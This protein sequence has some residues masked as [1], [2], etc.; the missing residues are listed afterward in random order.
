MPNSLCFYVSGHGYGH[1]R[2]M[3][4][5]IREFARLQPDA[6]IRI[7]SAAPARVFE[8][9]PAQWIETCDID[10]GLVEIDPLNIDREN[11]LRRL[12]AFMGRRG[13]IIATEVAAI[14]RIEP[15]LIVAD[16]PFLAGDV[17]AEAGVACVGISNFTWDWIYESLFAGDSR[18]AA[19]AG[20]IADGYAKL[21]ALLELP[22]GRTCPSIGRKIP[23]PLIAMRSVRKPAEILAQLGISPEDRRPRVLF[24]TRG[25]LPPDTLASAAA[26]ASG[27]LLLCPDEPRHSLPANAVTFHIGPGLDFSDVLRISDAVISKLGYGIVSEC[28][29]TQTRLVW[30]PRAGFAE[31]WVMENEAPQYLPMLRMPVEDFRAGRWGKSLSA[32]MQLPASTQTMRTDGAAACAG[33]IA[34]Q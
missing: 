24:G 25:G 4:Q 8:P 15:R 19:A 11:S 29:A 13:E 18:Y 5:V 9:L 23:T 7:R 33:F 34:D 3:T 32:A 21:S 10:A 27:F 16:I 26:N 12:L 31:D 14:R 22:F 28:I 2:R 30:P 17:A 1:A 6:T 20:S